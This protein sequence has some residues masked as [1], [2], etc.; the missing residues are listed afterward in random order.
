MK[1]VTP[2]IKEWYEYLADGKLM[3]LKC[4]EC[5]HMEFP[6]LPVCNQCGCMDM[7]WAEISGK[8]TMETF[9]WSP[10]GNA[11]Y[12]DDEIVCGMIRTEEGNLIM[13]N[14]LDKGEEDQE[15]LFEKM[16]LPVQAEI[17]KISEDPELYYPAWRIIEED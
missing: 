3:G 14:I 1:Q 11:P 10:M 4:P 9:S 16:P 17:I 6:P 15:E 8:G 7:E 13:G 12:F 2:I 5:G